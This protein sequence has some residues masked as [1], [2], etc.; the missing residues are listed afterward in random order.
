MSD[1]TRFRDHCR[2]MAADGT[3]LPGCE[4]LKRPIS[5][6][7]AHFVGVEPWQPPQCDGC[8]PAADRALFVRLADEADAY[9]ERDEAT[10]WEDA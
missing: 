1:L 5:Q 9:L 8:V 4:S 6:W 7:E 2:T 3:H 10:L